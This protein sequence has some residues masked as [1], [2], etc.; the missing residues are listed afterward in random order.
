MS[1]ILISHID[2]DG[3]G[4][5]ILRELFNQYLHIDEV[6]C[7]D[8]GFE[9]NTTLLEHYKT[10]DKI[11]FTDISVPQ[12]VAEELSKTS[13][14]VF[15][16]H[17]LPARWLEN[18][19]GSFYSEDECGTSLFWNHYVKPRIRRYNPVV[20]RVVELIDTYDCWKDT[21]PLWDDAVSLNYVMYSSRFHVY[22]DKTPLAECSRFVD[23]MVRKIRENTTGTWEWDDGE[24]EIIE[25]QK[26][27]LGSLYTRCMDNIDVREDSA[28]RVFGVIQASSK[29][30]LVCSMILKNNPAFDY[31]VCV[32]SFNGVNGKISYRTRDRFDLNTIGMAHGHASAAAG[33]VTPDLAL[34]LLSEHELTPRY[35]NDPL[36][37]EKDME[38]YF[39]KVTQ[40]R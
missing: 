19:P 24:Q 32:N 22:G 8:Y 6:D 28:G 30:S 20:D 35:G 16:D 5:I 15:M 31:L 36:Y 1:T 25:L 12:E 37:D 9:S 17:H 11:L 3:M 7:R 2:L 29:I 38:S 18:R 21:S 13:E 27:R 34:R 33:T 10:F 39:S 40:T 4:P 14:V 23:H 26:C